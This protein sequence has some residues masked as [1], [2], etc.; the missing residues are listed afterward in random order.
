MRSK[1]E[2]A[3]M[4]YIIVC[5]AHKHFSQ[6]TIYEAKNRHLQ[7]VRVEYQP[8][9]IPKLL[10]EFPEGAP[11]ALDSIGNWYW[12][13]DEIEAAGRI[14]LLAHVVIAKVMM[15]NGNKTDR[16]DA[17]DLTTLLRNGSLPTIWISPGE[18]RDEREPPRTPMEICI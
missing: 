9:A 3:K 18:V 12:I 13:V 1:K 15:G 16:L 14:P 8:R 10:S 6:F 2:A 17:R 5:D 7:Q 11:V 4:N